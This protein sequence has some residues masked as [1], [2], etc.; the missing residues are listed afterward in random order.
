MKKITVLALHL[1]YGG[2]ERCISSLVNSL[3]SDYKI[4]IISTYKL[5]EEPSFKIDNKVKI[6]YLMTDLKPNKKELKD[7]LKKLKLITFFKEIK[8]SLKIL[9]LKKNLMINAIKNCDS[10]III[11]TRDIHNLWLSKYGKKE[12]LKIGWE[13]NH[14]HGNKRYINKIIKSVYGLDYFVLVSKDLTEFYSEKLKDSKVECVYIPNSIDYFPEVKSKLETENLV[15]VGRLSKEKGYSDLIDIFKEIHKIYPDSKLDIIG[16]GPEREK[17]ENKIK[18]N[19][20]SHTIKLHGFQEKEYIN[21]VLKKASVY[22]MTS[23]TESFGIVLLEAFSFGIPCVA[24]DS[25]E[26]ARE[27]ISNNWDGYLVENRDHDKMVKRICE[28]LANRNRR[29]VMGANGLKKAHEFDI[30]KTKVKWTKLLNRK[31]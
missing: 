16:D 12:I 22:V 8:K 27:I 21:Q 7:S 29:L 23:H 6:D 1:G 30:E 31:K 20:L 4:N 24:F 10:D 15:S 25:A 9:K 14:H 5:Y 18:D 19:K 11:S 3:S 13:H 2:I 28:L 17:L 26:G